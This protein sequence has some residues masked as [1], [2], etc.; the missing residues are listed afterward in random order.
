MAHPHDI[1]HSDPFDTFDWDENDIRDLSRPTLLRFDD[2]Q[3]ADYE[4]EERRGFEAID[5][6][7]RFR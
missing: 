5:L 6:L 3:P 1:S 7:D 2:S 4:S